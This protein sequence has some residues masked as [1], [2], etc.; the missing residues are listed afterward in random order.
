MEFTQE[1]LKEIQAEFT[2]EWAEFWKRV[3]ERNA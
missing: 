1:L 2:Q 3:E